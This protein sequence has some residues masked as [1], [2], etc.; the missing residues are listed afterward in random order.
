MYGMRFSPF[1]GGGAAACQ[2]IIIIIGDGRYISLV[3]LRVLLLLLVDE[4]PRRQPNPPD[5][6][7]LLISLLHRNELFLRRR[8]TDGLG[9]FFFFLCLSV[10]HQLNGTSFPFLNA[11]QAR[12]G[13]GGGLIY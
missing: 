13:A 1:G 2:G 7:P 12:K 10:W 6:V 3:R 5:I 9:V 11:G 8:E 4:R